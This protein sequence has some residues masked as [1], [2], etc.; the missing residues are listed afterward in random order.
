MCIKFDYLYFKRSQQYYFGICFK[1]NNKCIKSFVEELIFRDKS[2]S[3][4]VLIIRNGGSNVL[5]VSMNDR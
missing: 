2:F 4:K 3:Q 1:N 5:Q